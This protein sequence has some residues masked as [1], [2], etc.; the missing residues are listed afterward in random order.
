MFRRYWW[1][2]LLWIEVAIYAFFSM[3]KLRETFGLCGIDDYLFWVYGTT[4]DADTQFTIFDS[5]AWK[6]HLLSFYLL[7]VF[8]TVVFAAIWK[9]EHGL[10]VSDRA[11]Q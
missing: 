1:F 2:V 6:K 9:E 10:R 4:A 11:R 7:I 8:R 5:S 3:S